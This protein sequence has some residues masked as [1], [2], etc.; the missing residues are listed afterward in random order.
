MEGRT[1]N[2]IV[3]DMLEESGVFVVLETG[4]S[5]DDEV[6]GV[7]ATLTGAMRL[8]IETG[9][10]TMWVSSNDPD[11]PE[12]GEVIPVTFAL[13]ANV[14]EW[15]DEDMVG[16]IRTFEMGKGR[17]RAYV[18]DEATRYVVQWRQMTF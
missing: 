3:A 12:A 7:A 10:L 16:R 6:I 1:V 18:Q 17:L 4:Y 5:N 2:D 13:A 15:I 9:E 8:V 14:F 11:D